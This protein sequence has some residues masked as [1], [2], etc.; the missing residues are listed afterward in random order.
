M[1][2]R[3]QICN[4]SYILTDDGYFHMVWSAHMPQQSMPQYWAFVAATKVNMGI[5]HS[6][7]SLEQL[8]YSERDI[9]LPPRYISSLQSS[10]MSNSAC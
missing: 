3:T 6:I 1:I 2:T 7:L 10:R 4:Y 9:K 5:K 8:S